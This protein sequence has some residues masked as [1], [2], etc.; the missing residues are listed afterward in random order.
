[1][2]RIAVYPYLDNTST[3]EELEAEVDTLEKEIV[4]ILNNHTKAI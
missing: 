1:L 4:A 2:I 3:R